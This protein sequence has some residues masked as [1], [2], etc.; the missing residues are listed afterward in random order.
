LNGRLRC[1]AARLAALHPSQQQARLNFHVGMRSGASIL[2]I[3]RSLKQKMTGRSPDYLNF[4]S[5]QTAQTR[6]A[7]LSTQPQCGEITRR[8]FKEELLKAR[9]DVRE[10]IKSKFCNPIIVRLA[11]HDSGTYDK[12]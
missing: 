5:T 11:W 2:A 8:T 12:V 10:L 9:Q 4:L 1:K 7:C 3:K 6:A